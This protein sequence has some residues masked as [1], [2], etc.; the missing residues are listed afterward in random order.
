MGYAVAVVVLADIAVICFCMFYLSRAGRTLDDRWN[1]QR[2]A[3]EA[4]RGALE[5]LVGDADE[6]ARDFDR[7]LGARERHLRGLLYRLAEQEERVRRSDTGTETGQ[8]ATPGLAAEIGQ[9]TD[10][11]LGPVEVARKLNVEPAQVRLILGL[12]DQA[13][14]GER[15]ASA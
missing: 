12:H 3:L 9:L 6:R 14:K 2:K 4:A 13:E 1:E 10:A 7:V 8:A 11:G 5:R 15:L